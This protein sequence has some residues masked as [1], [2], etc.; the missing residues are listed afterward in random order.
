MSVSSAVATEEQSTAL[1]QQRSYWG[2]E[3]PGKAQPQV[4]TERL[5]EVL[6]TDVIFGISVLVS[7]FFRC[8]VSLFDSPS[9]TWGTPLINLSILLPR[10]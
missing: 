10:E 9:I 3:A 2:R 5:A 1:N 8:E 6:G 7:S 4:T